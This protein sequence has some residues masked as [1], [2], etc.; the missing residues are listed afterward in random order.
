VN[1]SSPSVGLLKAIGTLVEAGVVPAAA[2]SLGRSAADAGRRMNKLILDEVEAFSVSGNPEVGPDLD[3]HGGEHIEEI[4]RL[5]AGG[6]VGNF[7]FV[8]THAQRRA[9]QHFPLEATL[10]AYRCGHTVLSRWLRDAAVAA[11]KDNAERAVAAVAD[12]SI[13]YTNAISTIAAAE[14]VAHARA[15]A[16]SEGDYRA[17]LLRLLLSGYDESDARAVRLLRRAGYLE[18]RQSYCVALLQ[19]TVPLEMENPFR[20]QRIADAVIDAVG[21]TPIRTLSGIRD[22]V[23]ITVFSETRRQ[24]GWTAPRTSL[25]D[26]VR[27]LLEILGPAV[28]VGLSRDHPST[29]FIPKAL[30]E[31]TVAFG[32]ARVTDRVVPFS[33][34]PIRRLLL[35]RAGSYVQSALP[36]WLTALAAADDKARGALLQ[37]LRAYADADMNVQKTAA[38]LGVHPNTVY[39]RMVKIQELTGLDAQRF[40]DLTELL[41]A[42]DCRGDLP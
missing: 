5:A 42:A 6:E 13:E 29:A 4:R 19:S 23:V 2:T 17:E 37:T 3:R 40:H 10:H 7:D 1:P 34:L 30:Q 11:V 9:E 31:A 25:A 16:K 12:F 20:A 26:R 28:L 22:N 27:P 39:G 36:A 24:S 38:I 32:F 18:Q 14:Y 41:L 15:I 21:A 33:R 8:R 35:H